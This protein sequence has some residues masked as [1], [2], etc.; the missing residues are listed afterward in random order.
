[1]PIVKSNSNY[2]ILSSFRFPYPSIY[3]QIMMNYR[4]PSLLSQYKRKKANLQKMEL[5]IYL[6]QYQLAFEYQGE[7]HY[8]DHFLY[9]ISELQK[10]KDNEKRQ[11]CLSLGITLI[12]IPY[13][14]DAKEESLKQ[15]IQRY[16][17]DIFPIE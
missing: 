2:I 11:M 9:W 1:M 5:D 10:T 15:V 6:P 14:W 16:R 8:K 4:H 12:E 17:P 7:H 3:F 13:W